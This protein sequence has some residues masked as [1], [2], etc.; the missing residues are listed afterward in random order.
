MTYNNIG[1]TLYR[2]NKLG[3]AYVYYEKAL[4]MIETFSPS[5]F[6]HND[7]AYTLKNMG[8]VQLARDNVTKALY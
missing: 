7:L 3:E 1:K 4:P 6:D 5:T 2:L 8:E